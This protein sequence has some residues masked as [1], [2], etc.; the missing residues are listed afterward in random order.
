MT[1]LVRAGRFKAACALD[2]SD[3]LLPGC[4]DRKK[5]AA[6]TALTINETAA[7]ARQRILVVSVKRKTALSKSKCSVNGRE[8]PDATN[9]YRVGSSQISIPRLKMC[10]LG[11]I[12][13]RIRRIT[14]QE[15]SRL[16]S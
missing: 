13:N 7:M 3:L 5:I 1:T 2:A 9:D 15:K 8:P 16:E 14:V 12:Q 4:Q 11:A 10:L 6:M